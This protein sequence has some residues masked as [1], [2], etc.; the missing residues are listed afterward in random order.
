M[1][2][3]EVIAELPLH[4]FHLAGVEAKRARTLKGLAARAIRLEEASSMSFE[5]ANKRLQAF[6]GVGPWTSGLV[7]LL[8]LGDTDAFP[9]GNYHFPNKVAWLLAGEARASET[10]MLELLEP[11][12]TQRG[13]VFRLMKAAGTT[14]PRRGPK[15]TLSDIRKC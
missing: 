13:R 2:A 1:P 12:V 14:A 3:P 8:A 5:A 15:L 9:L 7:R 6:K 10:R 4:D 11:Y